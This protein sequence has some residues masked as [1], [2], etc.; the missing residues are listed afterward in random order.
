MIANVISLFC[1]EK[2]HFT[3]H[4]TIKLISQLIKDILR[5]L[6]TFL[7]HFNGIAIFTILFS[8]LLV[9]F[10]N[11]NLNVNDLNILMGLLGLSL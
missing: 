5:V 1:L 4:V 10:N 2:I 8:A 11:P 7:K 3:D 6:Q 9:L